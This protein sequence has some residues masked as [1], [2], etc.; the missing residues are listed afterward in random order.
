MRISKKIKVINAEEGNTVSAAEH[1]LALILNIYKGISI[2][3]NKI[4][5]NK[6]SD[7]G[8]RRNELAGKT[9]GIIGFGKVGSKVGKF[10]KAFGMKVLANDTDRSVIEKNKRFKF[11][12]LKTLLENSDIV[13]LHIPLNTKNSN[14]FSEEKFSHLKNDCVFINTSRG[15]V[16]DEI[17]LIKILKSKK[18]RYAGLDVFKN[19]PLIN[20]EF[21]RLE[22]TLITN[23]TAG[24]TE[25]SR[26]RISGY[27]FDKI[28]RT[29]E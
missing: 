29:F 1:T 19:E 22:N 6:F 8:F 11:V 24:K 27:I 23:H 28:S 26:R 14:F 15:G 4:R 13:T 9:I 21:I 25:E 18:I 20:P 12:K 7:T 10:C 3:E 17:S 2:S 5:K 16:T